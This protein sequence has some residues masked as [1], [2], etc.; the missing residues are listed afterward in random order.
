[1]LGDAIFDTARTFEGQIFRLDDH[2][3]RLD[4]SLTA[5]Y[6]DPGLS[7]EEMTQISQTVVEKN[8]PLPEKVTI[9]GVS[10]GDPR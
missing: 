10:V 7:P 8:L 2:I 4:R 1:M 3:N 5:V 6:M 9:L